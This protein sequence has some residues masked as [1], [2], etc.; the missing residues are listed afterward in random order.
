M[1]RSRYADLILGV[2]ALMV[3]ASVAWS[4]EVRVGILTDGPASRE[5]LSPAALSREAAA[6]YGEDLTLSVPP[7]QQLNGAWSVAGL[8]AALDRLEA[9]PRV[10]VVATESG[11][12]WVLARFI[13]HAGSTATRY[14]GH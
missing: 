1:M 4:R 14:S 3:C 2:V 8:N 11:P 13:P 9:D 12:K 7:E 10:D 6:I 5:L